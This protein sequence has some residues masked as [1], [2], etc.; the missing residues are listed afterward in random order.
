M[1]TLTELIKDIQALLKLDD[2]IVLLERKFQ[3]L[4]SNMTHEI[5]NLKGRQTARNEADKYVS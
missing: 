4:E 5:A 2:K 3:L 1:D